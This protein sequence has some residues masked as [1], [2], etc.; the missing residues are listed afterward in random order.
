MRKDLIAISQP[1]SPGLLL[2]CA[3]DNLETAVG[4][5]ARDPALRP[6]LAAIFQ[7]QGQHMIWKLLEWMTQ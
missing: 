4:K 6:F 7:G 5:K 3:A 1:A 2:T